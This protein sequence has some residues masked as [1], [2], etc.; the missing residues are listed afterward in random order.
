IRS[1]AERTLFVGAGRE[2]L[3]RSLGVQPQHPISVAAFL[4][5]REEVTFAGYLA[6]LAALPPAE[7]DARR[8]RQ[9]GVEIAFGADG[10]PDLAWVGESARRGQPL[11]LPARGRHACRD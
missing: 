11:C 8:P 9:G 6:F 2:V 5:A 4:I 10:T 1:A 3:P 7:R